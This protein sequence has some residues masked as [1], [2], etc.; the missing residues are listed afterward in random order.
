VQRSPIGKDQPAGGERAGPAEKSTGRHPAGTPAPIRTS[1]VPRL[2]AGGV[3]GATDLWCPLTMA[4]DS[5]APDLQG[6]E[7]M[8]GGMDRSR[9]KLA[10]RTVLVGFRAAKVT[11]EQVGGLRGE[12]IAATA[13][14]RA[15]EIL[16]EI[17]QYGTNAEDERRMARR[18]VEG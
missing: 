18:E 6:Q 11:A 16:D 14:R 5:S 13:K 15:G 12:E 10:V 3:V 1:T 17:D 2:A 8:A 9:T 7:R 4:L